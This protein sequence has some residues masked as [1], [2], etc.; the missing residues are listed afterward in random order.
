LWAGPKL[1]PGIPPQCFAGRKRR[2]T[3]VAAP[4]ALLLLAT[5]PACSRSK[6]PRPENSDASTRA[7]ASATSPA[8]PGPVQTEFRNVDF[9]VGSGVVLHIRRLRGELVPT[10]EDVPPTFDDRSSFFFKMTSGLVDM[11]PDDLARLMN[12]YVFAYPGA[13]LRNIKITISGEQ[14]RPEGTLR[15]GIG[16]PFQIE[17]SISA[18]PDGLVRLHSTR[19]KSAHLPVKGLMDLLGVKLAGMVNLNEA[20]GVR[21][22]GDDIFLNPKR[23]IPPPRIEGKVS[24]ARIENGELVLVF[25]TGA[26]DASDAAD[27]LPLPDPEARNY[28][29]FRG[30][31]LRFGKLTMVDSDL[32]I[33]DMDSSDPFDFDFD[34][35]KRQ[36]VAGYSKS[37]ATGGLITFMPDLHRLSRT[38]TR[39]TR[40][41]P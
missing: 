34:E 28:M 32:E 23:M 35:Y 38:N 10:H 24:A 9:H 37:T 8:A 2:G 19:I 30:G 16:I 17:G 22:A 11:A 5:F 12:H 40:R 4:V 21:V 36:L 25:G 14:V 39:P 18:T 1:I 15:K 3:A 26:G 29:Y 13:P 27:S 41:G 33:V 7:E 20:R 6:N 31:T